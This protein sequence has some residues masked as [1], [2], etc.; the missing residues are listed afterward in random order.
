MLR[1]A[2]AAVV[3]LLPSSDRVD[4]FVMAVASGGGGGAA[5]PQPQDRPEVPRR[6]LILPD[7]R[8]EVLQ[9]DLWHHHLK[10]STSTP[11][12]RVCAAGC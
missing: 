2:V 5:Q 6:V 12:S 8:A 9:K 3:A 11:D 7:S 1:L 4:A 10:A